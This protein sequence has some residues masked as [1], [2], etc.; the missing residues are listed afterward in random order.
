M[1]RRFFLIVVFKFVFIHMLTAQITGIAELE[2]EVKQGIT[3]AYD[4]SVRIWGYDTVRNAQNSSQFSGVVVTKDGTILTV[5]H[6]IQPKRLYKVRFPDGRETLAQALGKIGDPKMSMR[7]DMG[8]LK[9]LS[10]G[11]W[12][13]AEMGWSHQV[14]AGQPCIGISYPETLNQLQPTV[15]FGE[16]LE[17]V[18]QHGFVW[19]SCKMEP[20]DSGGPLFDLSGRVI[21]LHSRCDVSENENFEVPIDLYRKYW[22]ALHVSETYEKLPDQTDGFQIDSSDVNRS[23]SQNIHVIIDEAAKIAPHLKQGV[24]TLNSTLSDTLQSIIGTAFDMEGTTYLVS[25]SSM[26]GSDVKAAIDG[27]TAAAKVIARDDD[28]DLVLLTIPATFPQPIPY[29][30]LEQDLLFDQNNLGTFLFA[31][32]P[33]NVRTGVL[34]S[35]LFDLPKRFSAAFLGAFSRFQD[36]KATITRVVPNSPA[37]VSGMQSSDVVSL[38]NGVP[39]TSAE[40]YNSEMAKYAAGSEVVFEGYRD[41]VP[42]SV[43]VV[44]GQWPAGNHPADRF[45]GGK[46]IRLDD[47]KE[48]YCHDI[49]I[50]ASECGGPVF[51]RNG[52]FYGINIARF[53]RTSVIAVPP[54]SVKQFLDKNL[55][56][57]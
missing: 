21:G 48:V 7:P 54:K 38:I 31:A 53:S 17:T 9:I 1:Y 23:E 13:Y 56:K 37:S 44:L 10:E 42:Y 15:R 22:T 27:K 11:E 49:R 41:T 51:D 32:L 55:S 33:G 6:A 3:M 16:V 57:Q 2:Y 45:A 28:L 34:S 4:A 19:T 39:I 18:T 43:K 20:G 40:V 36:G 35:G 8:M 30:D 46:S 47:F 26:V 50:E 12:P 29:G 5:A 14:K 52:R 24:L 25:K